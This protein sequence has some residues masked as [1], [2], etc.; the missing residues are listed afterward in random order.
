MTQNSMQPVILPKNQPRDEALARLI[1]QVHDMPANRVYAV[2]ITERKARRSD[3]QNRYLWGCVYPTI[4]EQ[5][6]E[7]LS[8]WRSED[9]HE[10]FLGEWSGWETLEGFGKK[11]MR[12]LRRSS[13]LNRTEFAEYVD[14]IHQ[15]AAEIGIVIPDPDPAYLEDAA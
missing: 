7:A 15:R 5:G 4:I 2:E 10:Y 1:R 12:P 11:R 8:G 14:F 6:G 9:V 13:R 3:A